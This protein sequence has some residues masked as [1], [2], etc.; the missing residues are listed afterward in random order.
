[1]KTKL[2]IGLV[3]IICFVISFGIGYNRGKKSI[4]IQTDTV[5]IEHVITEYKPKYED[6]KKLTVQKIK[7]PSFVILEDND[8]LKNIIDTLTYTKDSLEIELQRIQRY[9]KTDDYEAWVS[10]IDPALDSI[11]VKRN[12]EYITKTQTI[13][14]DRFHFNVGIN[15]NTWLGEE[16]CIL[17]PNLNV[18]YTYKR[19]TFTGEFGVNIP[20]NN[21]AGTLPYLEVGINYSLWS[22]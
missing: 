1:M 3:V 20:A 16:S 14:N 19:V 17:N 4:D 21:T 22:F 18:N 6:E 13:K 9:Y 5:K 11:K 8:S 15:G 12:V 10:G 7:I 2:I